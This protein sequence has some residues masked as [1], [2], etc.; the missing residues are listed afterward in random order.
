VGKAWN[1]TEIEV[2]SEVWRSDLMRREGLPFER[3]EVI[4]A[5]RGGLQQ[6]NPCVLVFGPGPAGKRCRDCA[7]LGQRLVPAV[8]LATNEDWLRTRYFCTLR[9]DPLRDERLEPEHRVRWPACARFQM[10]TSS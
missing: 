7:H 10:R 4:D 8:R 3:R 2:R 6:P 5:A 1:Q 9:V